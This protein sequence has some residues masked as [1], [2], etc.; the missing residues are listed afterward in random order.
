MTMTNDI[1]PCPTCGTYFENIFEATDHLLEDD[2]DE[3]DPELHLPNG[4]SLG[5]G[6]LLRCLFSHAMDADKI[7]EVTQ[8][9]YATLYASMVN[10]EGMTSYIEDLIVDSAVK[11][12]DDEL[13]ELLNDY[14]DGEE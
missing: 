11:N 4:Y 1:P 7:R 2:E 9:T 8:H 3:F 10:P 14:R 6:S 5:V 12:I 13:D